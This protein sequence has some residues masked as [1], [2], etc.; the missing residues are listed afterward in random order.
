MK[1]LVPLDRSDL[2][3][4]AVPAVRKLLAAAPDAELHLM[5]VLDPRQVRGSADREVDLVPAMPA[6]SIGPVIAPVKPRLVESHGEAM[7]RVNLE[8]CAELQAL[9]ETEFAGTP[10][11]VRTEWSRKPADKIVSVADAIDA[12][13][14]V[15]A[16]RAR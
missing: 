4:I 3:E 1:V 13:V 6:G 16:T 8:T 10:V 11:L 5:T 15:M 9:A 12:G 14:I 2:K 7:E